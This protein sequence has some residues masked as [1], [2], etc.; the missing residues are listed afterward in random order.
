MLDIFGAES[1]RRCNFSALSILSVQKET[2][3]L[4]FFSLPGVVDCHSN[5]MKGHCY[6]PM[7]SDLN[8]VFGHAR[9]AEIFME[10]PGLLYWWFRFLSM[11][12][13]R[14]K[15]FLTVFST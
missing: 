2:K 6:W 5:I 13:V 9:V 10:D 7:V 1:F 14:E 15:S 4:S 3:E 12:Q 11:F 8:N